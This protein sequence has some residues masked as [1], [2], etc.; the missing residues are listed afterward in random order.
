M[1]LKNR[2]L[3]IVAAAGLILA[4]VVAAQ[5]AKKA[6]PALPLAQPAQAPFVSYIGGAGM[7]EA[8]TENISIGASLPGTVKALFVKVGDRTR[9]GDGLFQ[10]DGREFDAELLVRQATLVKARAA[11]NEARA[12]L[13]D[14]RSQYALVRSTKDGRAVSVDDVQ[15]RRNAE[16]I[17]QAKLESAKA[18]V[19][20][21][22]AE[23]KSTETT[24][25][26]L[27]VR[28]PV[29]CEV[30]Q[31]NIRLGEYAQTG[32]LSTPLMRLGN[33]DRM[34]VR[35]DIDEN[36]A[37]RFRSGTKAIAFMR[38]NRD[39]KTDLQFV[40]VEPFITPKTSLTGS[41]TERVDT[42]VL[43]VIYRF[44]PKD[45]PAYVGQQMDVFIETPETTLVTAQKGTP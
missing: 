23:L 38:G 25:D 30:L 7:V 20:V 34:H 24:L 40:R 36:D 43:Q 8:S 37:W 32:V 26:R 35:V 1:V 39:L 11:V 13:E 22:E 19:A 33:I 9:A 27:T 44:D 6:P 4:C 45:L 5:S 2:K 14:Y 41:S 28:A 42:R 3:Q 17:A 21:A 29:D 12:S 16:S 10:I 15:K 18:Q 31:I